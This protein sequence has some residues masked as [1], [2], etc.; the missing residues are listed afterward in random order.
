MVKIS[1]RSTKKPVWFYDNKL[2]CFTLVE[3]FQN[4]SPERS[5]KTFVCLTDVE[6][7]RQ[8]LTQNH[9]HNTAGRERAKD[10]LSVKTL[11]NGFQLL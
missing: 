5:L 10:Q 8:H 7:N 4:T 11:E 3:T 6:W 2:K 1:F 9:V